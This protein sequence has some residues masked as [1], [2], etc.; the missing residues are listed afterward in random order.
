M[1]SI[2]SKRLLE[3]SLRQL[4]LE[5]SAAPGNLTADA[6]RVSRMLHIVSQYA[7]HYGETERP[8]TKGAQVLLE[9]YYFPALLELVSHYGVAHHEVTDENDINVTRYFNARRYGLGLTAE[10]KDAFLAQVQLA[11]LTRDS[12]IRDPEASPFEAWLEKQ[13]SL[14]ESLTDSI[15]VMPVTKPESMPVFRDI[16]RSEALVTLTEMA[17]Y[18]YLH[19]QDLY[20]PAGPEY[21]LEN[22]PQR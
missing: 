19:M 1:S 10:M 16:Q 2:P 13:A 7:E 22:G 9:E 3:E 14:L 20:G 11:R 21:M 15:A 18:S 12:E 6:E 4:S 8:G 5:T 17:A